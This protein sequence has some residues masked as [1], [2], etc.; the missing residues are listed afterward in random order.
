MKT[1]FALLC[2]GM[3][4]GCA[5]KSRT[6]ITALPEIQIQHSS[7][8][9]PVDEAKYGD[10][11]EAVFRHMFRPE[12]VKNDVSHN[13]NLVHKVYFVSIADKDPTAEFLNRFRDLKT[14][15]KAISEG[16]WKEFFI[17]DKVTDQRG[18]A[19]YI[20]AIRIINDNEMEV[21]AVIHPGGGLSASGPIY[22]LIREGGKWKVS[23]EKLKW[24]S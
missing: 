3:L 8:A 20:E 22:R 11:M 15:V 16:N 19:F 24:I 23:G 4:I 10:L 5:S 21:E 6:R 7:V 14:P 9:R 12:P 17:F 2:L 13:V 1:L 18:A